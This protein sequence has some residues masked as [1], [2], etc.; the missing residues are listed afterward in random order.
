MRHLRALATDAAGKLDVLGHDGH[1][2]GVDG[3]QVGILE[4]ANKVC[5]GSL[6]QSK[7]GGALEAQIRLE[8]LG[9]LANEALERKL[10]DEQ[11]RGL[12]V[13][14]DLAK[15]HG[16]GAVAMGLLDTSGGRCRLAGCLGGELLAGGFASGALAGGLLG[17]G[18]FCFGFVLGF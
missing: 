11:V 6:L 12:L 15:S 4:E 17:A 1:T 5:L 9:D 3:A 18:H 10:A 16:T 13:A 7:D 8:V 14:A 2:L